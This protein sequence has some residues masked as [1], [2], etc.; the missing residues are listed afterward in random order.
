MS[1]KR[2]HDKI[3]NDDDADAQGSGL[4]EDSPQMHSVHANKNEPGTTKRTRGWGYQKPVE[5]DEE[6]A[7]VERVEPGPT[8]DL[9]NS[10]PLNFKINILARELDAEPVISP[11]SSARGL[12]SQPIIEFINRNIADPTHLSS[13]IPTSDSPPSHTTRTPQ[14]ITTMNDPKPT[15]SSRAARKDRSQ[16]L[17]KKAFDTGTRPEVKALNKAV[18]ATV[19]DIVTRKTEVNALLRESN[20]LRQRTDV[21]LPAHSRVLEAEGKAL[22]G[23]DK[24]GKDLGKYGLHLEE[25]GKGLKAAGQLFEEYGRGLVRQGEGWGDFDDEMD[26]KKAVLKKMMQSLMQELEAEDVQKE[27]EAEVKLEGE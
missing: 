13:Y 22:E 27:E 6:A 2:S 21:L 17:L 3:N 14:T 25:Y 7:G 9:L 8:H 10:S 5:D 24:Y 26:R 18:E 19:E 1:K 20:A 16:N 12:P 15:T 4:A 23:S 11:P